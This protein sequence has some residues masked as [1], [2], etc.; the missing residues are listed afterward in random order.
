MWRARIRAVHLPEL[1]AQHSAYLRVLEVVTSI[2]IGGAERVALD[3]TNGLAAQGI[4]AQLVVLGKPT[5]LALPAPPGM[6][7]LS[8]VRN[9]SEERAEALHAAALKFGADAIH[10]HLIR[11]VEA[12]AIRAHGWPLLLHIHNFPPGWPPDY[13]S[14]APGDATVLVACAQAVERETR[15]AWPG[16]AARTV[17]NGVGPCAKSRAAREKEGTFTVVILANP[18]AQKRLELLPAIARET[19]RRMAPRAVRFVLAGA[20]EAYSADS[21]AALVAFE[22]AVTAHEARDLIERA[23]LVQ[24]SGEL[25]R[26]A[27][28]LLS[29]SAYEGLSLAHLEALAAGVRVVATDAGGTR[30]IATQSAAMTLL[31][32]NAAPA[33]FAE[34][35]AAEPSVDVEL[36]K[37]FTR[38][39]MTARV[40]GLIPNAVRRT[41]RRR[42]DGVWLI[43]N[44]FSTGGA[45][46]SA[47]RLL[48][49]LRER[50]IRVRAA[51]VQEQ[52]E[53]PTEGRRALEAAGVRVLAVP[54]ADGRP[55]ESAMAPL[56]QAMEEDPPEAIFFWNLIASWKIRLADALLDARIFD[57]SPGEMY[58]SSMERFFQKVPAGLPYTE[59]G[60]YGARLAG[61]VVKYRAEA[62][63]AGQLGCP[64]TVIPN[65]VPDFPARTPRV[66]GKLVLGTA[67][68]LSPDKRIEDLLEALRLA[69]PKLPPFVLRVAGGPERDFPE[70]AGELR[71]LADGLPVEW[72]GH[73]SGME[74]FFGALD[75][76]VMISE[77]AGCPNALL[78]AMAAGLPVVATDH[79]GARE[80]VVDGVTGRVTPRG[81]AKAL[82]EAIVELML[83][84]E[85]RVAFGRAGRARAQEEFSMRRM[86]EGYVGL[87][88]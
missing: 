72:L 16:M 35:L 55:V 22:A 66:E 26:R 14:L 69:A 45:Q 53:F 58:F 67:A 5:R 29:V 56:A 25:L 18:R 76:F 88:K 3:L 36:P 51:V 60:D 47:R 1:D 38:Q 11:A 40:A 79:G 63:R 21:A 2:Q 70:H 87:M 39:A 17:W 24:D 23:G 8:H 61:V 7:D 12:R 10:A 33:D 52:P 84:A 13:G 57:V 64:V 54:L 80:L 83:D 86:V 20:T 31:P 9:Q 34:A 32:L 65:G 49:A 15:R 44:N 74:E 62:E 46:T 28:V 43:A 30:E 6:I 71:R 77:P 85:K 75:L 73:V 37:S 42:A 19:A 82:A 48:L 68:R 27:D 4:A 41:M 50:G 81:D 78:E 59:V